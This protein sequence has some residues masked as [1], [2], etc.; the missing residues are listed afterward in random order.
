MMYEKVF[1]KGKIN[2]CVLRNRV[3]MS[4]MDDCLGQASGEM[5]ARGVEYYASKAKGGTGL[6]IVGFVGVIG[7]EY[8]GV[9]MSGQTFLCNLDDR[10]TMNILADRVHE[11]GGKVFV[12]L[13]HPG[14]KSS[15]KFNKGHVPMSASAMTPQLEA[16]GFAPC[17]EMTKDD[18]ALIEDA[19]ANAAEHAYY[20]G[21]DGVELH[22]AHWFMFHQFIS[23]TRNCRTDEYGG[24]LE[25]RCRIVTET[26]AKIRAKVPASFPVT[27]R[28][29]LFDNEGM[30]GEPDLEEW[31]RV[32]KHL[33]ASGVDAFH[34]S[35]GV[36]E[37]TGAPDMPFGWR[38]EYL[39]RFKSELHVP[40]YGPNETKT[41]DEAE[42][43][44]EDDVCDFIVMG[45]QH[46]ADPE[47]CN[48][49][50]S[51]HPEDIRPCI[52]CNW[53]V[54]RVTAD[55][56]QVRCA[57][58]PLLGREVDNLMPMKKGEGTVIVIG[59]GPAGIQSALTLTERGFKVKLYDKRTELCG[60][61]NLANKAPNKF[62]MDNLIRYYKHVVA[63]NENIELHLGT[64]V[65]PAMLD[66]FKALDPYAVVLASG[67]QPIV[68]G[69][70]PGIEKG[71][72]CFDV[73][74]G[75]VKF[76][77]KHVAVVGGGMTGLETA[78][79]LA[80]DGNKVTLIEMMPLVGNG[81]YFYNVR[82]TR[83][84]LEAKGAVIKTSTALQ[85]V[86]DDCIVV[87]PAN[88]NYIGTGLDGIKNIAGVADAV[89]A[90]EH[91]GPYEIPVDATVLSLGIRPEL[92]MLEELESRFEKVIHVGDCTNPGRI[93]DATGAA[94]LAVKNL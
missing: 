23:P 57:V 85:E 66:E 91:D 70:I 73:L 77:G 15:P 47:W 28:V 69:K 59:A 56:A 20:A 25:N 13:N 93:G 2:G 88:V 30:E 32:T 9:S 74:N 40:I 75:K 5:T 26:I 51:G 43:L 84:Q 38:N 22:C 61:L 39:K 19:F 62:R 41:P 16:R 80:E 60:S 48:K 10:H 90:D 94:F 71:V 8:G 12:Q 1:S 3:I 72:A 46:S 86:K 89:V 14:R 45:R 21:C 55:Q 6:V 81:I 92:G 52:S 37:R 58:N 78:E 27:V 36:E 87:A 64:E 83:R 17:R 34:F 18:I 50:K 79:R 33:E 42:S 53:C 29:H 49:A 65:T 44:L 67:G 11:F 63:K 7:P 35:V 68:P 4:P 24:S 54:H 31:V 82:R 76:S